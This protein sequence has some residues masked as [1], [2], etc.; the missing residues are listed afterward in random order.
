MLRD[1]AIAAVRY[2]AAAHAGLRCTLLQPMKSLV[3]QYA[4]KLRYPNGRI[5]DYHRESELRLGVGNEFDAF[6]RTWR[7]ECDVPPSRFNPEHPSKPEAFLCH[8]VGES[9]LRTTQGR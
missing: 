5:F 1:Q 8:P 4:L 3:Y 9:G 7:I 2:R 6:G